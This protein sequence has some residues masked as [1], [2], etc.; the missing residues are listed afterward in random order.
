MNGFPIIGAISEDCIISHKQAKY[1][2]IYQEPETNKQNKEIQKTRVWKKE[3]ETK[4]HVL[5]PLV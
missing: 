2:P 3:A 5:L 1:E 4:S